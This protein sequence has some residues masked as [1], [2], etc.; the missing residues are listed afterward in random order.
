[1]S[2]AD[3][4]V[5]WYAV[6]GA[7]GILMLL[8]VAIFVTKL[9]SGGGDGG[10]PPVAAEAEGDET[11]PSAEEETTSA[12]EGEP[13]AAAASSPGAKSKDS[14]AKVKS[15]RAQPEPAA[16]EARPAGKPSD[17]P[18]SETAPQA[19]D[20]SASPADDEAAIRKC[21]DDYRRAMAARDGQAAV[22]LVTASTL[23]YY[24]RMRQKALMAGEPEVRAMSLS[25]RMMVLFYRHMLD[26]DQLQSK[27]GRE[28]F[29]YSV[30]QGWGGSQSAGQASLG[31][32]TVNGDS[33]SGQILANGR[34]APLQFS[35]A[36]EQ[37]AWKLDLLPLLEFADR[38]LNM[39]IQLGG[40]SGDA[41]VIEALQQTTGRAPSP[42]IWQ[43]LIKQ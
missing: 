11:T 9:I 23:D 4:R 38:T 34:P 19:R 5:V 16:G 7:A 12:A 42:D 2:S 15:P 18:S 28:L 21:L 39:A 20:T 33:A 13:S 35:F 40:Q 27:Q 31:T 1:M 26:V 17:V 3:R 8:A 43:P 36:K 24:D 32:I 14:A 29:V 30:E 41:I 6:G 10:E 37:G 25:D 22:A